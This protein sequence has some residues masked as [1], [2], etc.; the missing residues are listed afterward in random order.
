MLITCLCAGKCNLPHTANGTV[1]GN[2]P[3]V[4]NHDRTVE[5]KCDDG[6]KLNSTE[7][8]R[9]YNGSWTFIPGCKPGKQDL[10]LQ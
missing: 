8:P 1:K 4:V 10:R 6:F 7:P 9:C 2:L 3:D 5:F